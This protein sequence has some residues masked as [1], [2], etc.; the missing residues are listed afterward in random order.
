MALN[1]VMPKRKFNAE[2]KHSKSKA[3]KVDEAQETDMM[4]G[5]E[6]SEH[7]DTSVLDGKSHPTPIRQDGTT[8]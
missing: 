8:L 3:T 7:N 4:G 5:E 2:G 1:Y 6:D